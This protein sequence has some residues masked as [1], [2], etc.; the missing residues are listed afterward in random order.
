MLIG[1]YV[2]SEIKELCEKE[3]I[4]W[5]EVNTEEIYSFL[6]KENRGLFQALFLDGKL[7]KQA[8]LVPKLSFQQYLN[9]TSPFGVPYTSYQFFKPIDAS[10]ELSNNKED[11]QF[12]ADSFIQHIK[13]THVDRE[14]FHRNITIVREKGKSPEWRVKGKGN[15]WQGYV[16]SYLLSYEN[17]KIP[18]E[19]YLGT[20]GY[21]GNSKSTYADEQSRFIEV[22][23][24]TGTK[25][26]KTQY[27][28][29]KYLRTSKRG[30]YPF[31]ELK[32][33]AVGTPK[34]H[35]EDIYHT[36]NK[37]GYYVQDSLEK[38]PSKIL[39]LGEISL[40]D[41][42]IEKKIGELIEGLFAVTIVKAHY[43]G[44]EKGI[45]FN[46]FDLEC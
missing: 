40:N 34:K 6:Q 39:W 21:R 1:Q 8:D 43:K 13:D 7:Y 3:T 27:G 24:G 25:Q 10:P 36:L 9:E 30:L 2:P 14:L 32:F 33:N 41:S 35:W 46:F 38:K 18:C 37:F 23:V 19:V 26:V 44:A 22:R 42:L 5:K 45:E 29:H 4:E 15:A 17:M 20:I 11:N 16:I 12:V 31:Y 28:F